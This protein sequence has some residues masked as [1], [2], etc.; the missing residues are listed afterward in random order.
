MRYFW[1][2]PYCSGSQRLSSISADEGEVR[3]GNAFG[4]QLRR[5]DVDGIQFANGKRRDQ[6]L[7]GG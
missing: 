3:C 6:R 4:E 2:H 1:R 7:S 5:G